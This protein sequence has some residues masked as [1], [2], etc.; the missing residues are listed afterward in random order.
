[1][2][3]DFT[4]AVQRA[5]EFSPFLS[6]GLDRQ[7]ELAD[8][9]EKGRGEDA[10][11]WAHRAGDGITDTSVALRKERLG[12]AVALAIGDLAGLFP[13]ERVM[14][15]LSDFA[16]R[17]L[18]RAISDAIR[19]RVP[20]AEPRGFIALALGK[21]GAQELN[22]SSDIDPILLFDPETLPRRERDEPGEAAQRVARTLMETMTRQTGDGYVFRVDL[23][24]RPASEVSPLAVSLP[25]ALSHYESSALAWERAAF[26]RA[27]ASAGDMAAGQGFLDDIRPFIW[28]RSLDFTALEEIRRLTSRIRDHH[29]GPREPG[30][31]FNVKQGRGGIREVEFF[32]QT[33]Q[34]IHGG[35]R[36]ALRQRGTR[37][38]LDALAQEELISADDAMML[39]SSYDRLREIEH[40]LQ[41]V[42]DRQTHSLPDNEEALD[43][44]ARLDGLDDG[45]ALIEELSAITEKVAARYDRLLDRPGEEKSSLAVSVGEEG[46]GERVRQLGFADP[47]TL[48]ARIENWPETIRSLRSTE[49]RQAFDSILPALLDAFAKAPDP[50]H[51]LSRWETLLAR[52]PSA[53]N[54]FRLFE[55][56]PGLLDQVLRLLTLAPPLADE[57]SRR[58]ELL[59]AL[60]D[61]TALDLP[62][63]VENLR[64]RM[65][66][67]ERGDDYERRLDRIRQVVGEER[68]ALGTQLVE[69]RH[70]PLDIAAGLSRVAEAALQAGAEAAAEEFAQ[71]HGRVAGADLVILGLGRLGGGALTHASDLDIV[72][73]FSGGIGV[74]SDGRRP[75]TASLYF[76]RLAQRVT[77]ALSVPTAQGALYEVDTRLRPQGA[78]GPLSVSL[79]SFE[80]YQR[81]DAWTWE[82]MALTRARPLFGP[83]KAQ[84]R[85]REI[86]E[87]VLTAPRDREVL[88]ADILHMRNEM[89]RHKPPRGPLDAKLQRG[90]LID[91]EFAIHY[92]QLRD[93]VALKPDLGEAILELVQGNLLPADFRS[94][95]DSLTRLLVAARLFAPDGHVPGEV[96]QQAMAR[97]C[98][99]ASFDTLLKDL[100]K[101]RHGVAQVWADLFGEQLEIAR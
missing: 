25:A 81:E 8:L 13:L 74:E 51:A 96:G 24:L 42:Y 75:L 66:R 98:G 86:V 36:P 22:Y 78:Q 39:G 67:G 11:Q 82:H 64:R 87:N 76:N 70:D 15:E 77:A 83:E 60:I 49:A 43:G 37:A 6:L 88:R 35:R 72:Y 34:L 61:A 46:L 31:G 97:I 19:R 10:L 30:P 65:T 41:M 73:L 59:D 92:L 17:A 45:R 32:A 79:D 89:A 99:H 68:F 3:Y 71:A 85:L 84:Q 7:P 5:R 1:M 50:A 100:T 14:R 48:T 69:A 27:R 2:S 40:R 90:G 55:A 21:H 33:Y 26:I 54:L 47:E 57:L 52:L 20:D 44:V 91:C 53:I 28:R 56:R 101:A 93:G 80:R 16:D 4:S 29:S 12:L 38:T 23:R 63:S 94:W 9:L 58:P 95:Y 62:G 18:D